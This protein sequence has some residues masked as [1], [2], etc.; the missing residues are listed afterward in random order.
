MGSRIER[1]NKVSGEKLAIA[2]YEVVK[3]DCRKLVGDPKLSTSVWGSIGRKLGSAFKSITDRQWIKTSWE[4][5]KLNVQ[6]RI[7]H[8]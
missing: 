6:V 5:N 7:M 1:W 2:I 4:T 3:G 8:K